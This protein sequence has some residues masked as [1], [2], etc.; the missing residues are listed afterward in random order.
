MFQACTV[1]QLER[2]RRGFMSVPWSARMMMT[3]GGD[4]GS[5]AGET[6]SLAVE[7]HYRDRRLRHEH[8]QLD[9]ALWKEH[10]YLFPSAGRLQ[11]HSFLQG[12]SSL[13][14]LLSTVLLFVTIIIISICIVL[15]FFRSLWSLTRI[16]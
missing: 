4:H 1:L 7:S 2:L 13:R 11:P 12:L 9:L 14:L 5:S 6:S 8:V 16:L 10:P 3:V 15:V